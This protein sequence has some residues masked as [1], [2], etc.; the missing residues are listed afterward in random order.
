MGK[1]NEVLLSDERGP[2]PG[3]TFLTNHAHVLICLWQNPDLRMRE[4]AQAVGITE[5][6]VQ[7]IVV[8]LEGERYLSRRKTGRR[9]RYSVRLRRP[10]RHS[11]EDHLRIGDLMQLISES[12]PK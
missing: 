10:L 1:P 7:K 2:A 12:G 11:L 9:N 3:W 8:D 5:R 6:A 4:V